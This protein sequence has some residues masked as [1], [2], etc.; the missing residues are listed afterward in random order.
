MIID[1]TQTKLEKTLSN[2]QAVCGFC[3]ACKSYQL[4]RME[5]GGI[6]CCSCNAEMHL[7]CISLRG[8]KWGL[9]AGENDE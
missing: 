5:N 1:T 4:E 3:L 8:S 7:S 2:R 9:A 6:K